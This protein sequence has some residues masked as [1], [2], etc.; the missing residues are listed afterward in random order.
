M[1]YIPTEYYDKETEQII[2][3]SL[4]ELDYCYIRYNN[5]DVKDFSLRRWTIILQSL[6]ADYLNEYYNLR[7]QSLRNLWFKKYIEYPTHNMSL[8]PPTLLPL[9]IE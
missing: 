7:Y 6:N 1:T 3:N 9:E 2:Q 8:M 5:L 4:S